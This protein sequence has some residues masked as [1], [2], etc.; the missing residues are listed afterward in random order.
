MA[1]R[2]LVTFKKV[3]F[4][5]LFIIKGKRFMTARDRNREQWGRDQRAVYL[6]VSIK[7]PV[8]SSCLGL[9]SSEVASIHM[10][11]GS[12]VRLSI[13]AFN[14]E[15]LHFMVESIALS[16]VGERKVCVMALGI[17]VRHMLKHRFQVFELQT[18][19]QIHNT[20]L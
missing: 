5:S 9:C 8:L 14:T 6:N 3:L 7:L 11:K 12:T 19:K 13:V 17:C 16:L 10:P 4:F 2:K 15:K 20:S 18:W 1:K